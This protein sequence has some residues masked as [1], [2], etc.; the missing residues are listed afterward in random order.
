M[1]ITT[2][3]IE[4]V[5]KCLSTTKCPGPDELVTEC[6]RTPKRNLHPCYSDYFMKQKKKDHLLNSFYE[7]GI[8]LIPKLDKDT[9][10]KEKKTT[11]Q[12]L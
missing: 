1:S 9:T 12:F 11:D 10:Q 6:Y 8:T 4:K 3:K 5:T 2:F 7:S